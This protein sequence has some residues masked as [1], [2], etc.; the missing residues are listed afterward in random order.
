MRATASS[1]E[2]GRNHLEVGDSVF[3]KDSEDPTDIGISAYVDGTADDFVCG[4]HLAIARPSGGTHPR[5]LN[6][7]LRS[8]PVLDHFGTHATGISRYGIGLADLRSAPIPEVQLEQQ[9][10]IADFLDDHVS[11]IDKVI[12]ARRRQSDQAREAFEAWWDADTRGLLSEYPV[13]PLRRVLVSIADGP[14]GS[15][16][17]SKHYTDSGT[18]VIRLG[19][20]GV[21]SFRDLDRVYISDE[22]AES[23]S[24]HA[25]QAGDLLMA[26]LGDERWPLG[27]CA[28]VPDIGR[29]IV[30]A[31]CYRIRL[32]DSVSHHFAAIAISSPTIRSRLAVLGRGATRARLNT[33]IARDAQLPLAPHPVQ[34]DHA[35][36]WSKRREQLDAL[37]AGLNESVYLLNEYKGS[38]ITAAVTG[39]LDVTTAG[40]NIPG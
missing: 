40:S 30:K 14:F 38:L 24:S 1:D 35:A 21:A 31:D 12:V 20:I 8:R 2:I 6:W 36:A 37:I 26:G 39:E 16:L 9:R 13:V 29:A 3:T 32:T 4:Y 22:Y 19:N 28:V 5:F 34:T 7:S 25:V 15:S 33:E 18:R 11:R 17:A 10:R 27:R 23:L